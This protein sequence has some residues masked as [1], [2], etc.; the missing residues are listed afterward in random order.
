MIGVRE[1]DHELY[2][3]IAE[4]GT[5]K[6]DASLRALSKAANYS[7]LWMATAGALA[8]FGGPTGRRAAVT[9]MVS[10]GLTSAAVNQGFKRVFHRDRPT[11]L[12][13]DFNRHVRMPESTSFPSGH[14][15]SAF[16]FAQG[17]SDTM[18][19]TG[20]GVVAAA[21]AYSRVHTG[22]HYPLDVAAGAIIG[23]GLGQLTAEGVDRVWP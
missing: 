20:L 22:V 7:R 13:R 21:V 23:M 14:S 18:P 17:V 3:A 11:R 16:A 5:P 8:V 12:E 19:W 1:T 15:A 6:V 2:D 4:A 9:G 10:V